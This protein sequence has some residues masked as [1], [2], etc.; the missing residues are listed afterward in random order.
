[1]S[2]VNDALFG[3]EMGL[4]KYPPGTPNWAGSRRSILRAALEKAETDGRR[5]GYSDGHRDAVE[6]AFAEKEWDRRQAEE[7]GQ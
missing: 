5:Q 1:V 7:A 2:T 4:D 3:L 6:A